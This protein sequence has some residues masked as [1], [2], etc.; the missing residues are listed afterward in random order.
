MMCNVKEFES[1]FKL[2]NLVAEKAAK[3][4]IDHFGVGS[5]DEFKELQDCYYAFKVRKIRARMHLN[6]QNY[7]VAETQFMDLF[8]DEITFYNLAAD[9]SDTLLA[10]TDLPAFKVD[11]VPKNV[12]E[13]I[14]ATLCLLAQALTGKAK[15]S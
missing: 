8:K 15:H 13:Q 1:A 6:F 10:Q 11:K 5:K 9:K 14:G 4:V 12:L 2:V 3:K 7:H